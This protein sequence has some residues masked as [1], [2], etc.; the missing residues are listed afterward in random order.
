ML[1]VS[2]TDE[3]Q[4]KEAFRLLIEFWAD[5]APFVLSLKE[6]SRDL[7]SLGELFPF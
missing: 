7:V 1:A 4:G 5:L 2:F 3:D 6:A